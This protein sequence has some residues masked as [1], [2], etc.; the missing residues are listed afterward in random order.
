MGFGLRRLQ[1][2]DK[3]GKETNLKRFKRGSATFHRCSTSCTY[4]C[5]EL[6]KNWGYR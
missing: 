4:G 5:E 2:D 1:G 3:V 6:G